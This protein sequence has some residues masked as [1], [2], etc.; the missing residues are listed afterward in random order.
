MIECA[1]KSI[2]LTVVDLLTDNQRLAS[3]R[4]EFEDGTGRCVGGWRWQAPLCDYPPPINFRWPE[5]VMTGRGEQ[6]R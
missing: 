4:P 1:T 5:Y 3:A 2:G 6:W